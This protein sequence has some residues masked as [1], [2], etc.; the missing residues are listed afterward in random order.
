VR[1]HITWAMTG[2]RDTGERV[3]DVWRLTGFLLGENM[4]TGKS[5]EPWHRDSES[6]SLVEQ[7]RRKAA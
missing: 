7:G 3:Q 5:R 2:Q 1:L 4:R 6:A